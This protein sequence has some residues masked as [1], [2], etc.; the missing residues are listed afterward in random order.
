MG[1]FSSSSPNS[2][3]HFL[4][5]ARAASRRCW[6]RCQSPWCG[7]GYGKWQ[8]HLST[9]SP[10][11]L[12]NKK[13]L[14]KW[15]HEIPFAFWLSALPPMVSG[16][17]LRLG[18]TQTFVCTSS[19]AT[20]TTAANNL[21]FIFTFEGHSKNFVR[22]PSESWLGLSGSCFLNSFATYW[23]MQNDKA[24]GARAEAVAVYRGFPGVHLCSV[25]NDF[26]VIT[27]VT[28]TTISTFPN[29]HFNSSEEVWGGPTCVPDIKCL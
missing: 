11:S 16:L 26:Q 4:W 27:S 25:L 9:W 19:F 21:C 2:W 22:V 24:A 12:W 29:H 14:N 23:A 10:R 15:L 6:D 7:R 5:R 13:Q 18:F 3:S 1:L 8:R 28:M 17:S 20:L